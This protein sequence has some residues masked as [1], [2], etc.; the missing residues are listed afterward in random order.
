MA[1]H[2]TELSLG[3]P[4]LVGSATTEVVASVAAAATV[5][6]ESLHLERASGLLQA[7]TIVP[8]QLEDTRPMGTWYLS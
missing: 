8:P 6:S 2:K 7:W 5:G 3:P 4:I 1:F